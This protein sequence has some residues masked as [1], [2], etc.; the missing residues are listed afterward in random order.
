MKGEWIRKS[1]NSDL[2]VIFVHGFLS[3]GKD[4]WKNEE[5]NAYWPELLMN[6][7][8]LNSIGIY[9]YTYQTDFF[10]GS[11]NLGDVVDDLKE[12]LKLDHV[13]ESKNLVFVCHSMGGIVVRRY[14]VSRA[15]DL[16]EI[17]VGLYLVASPSLGSDYANWLGPIAQMMNHS[18]AD[19]LRFSQNNQWLNDL[20]KD[21]KNLIGSN[22]LT[23]YGKEIIED[24]FVILKK[25]VFLKQVV[26]P[27][28]GALYFPEPYKLPG[29]DHFSIAKPENKDSIQ[30]RL[31]LN[32]IALNVLQTSLPQQPEHKPVTPTE[33]PLANT[34][35]FTETST[36]LESWQIKL[37]TKLIEQLKKAELKQIVN[38]FIDALIVTNPSLKRDT[39]EIATYLVSGQSDRHLQ[40]A[41]YLTAVKSSPNPSQLTQSGTEQL[42]GYL[43]Q[44]LVRKNCESNDNGLT[45]IAVRNNETAKMIGASRTTYSYL[46]IYDENQREHKNGQ[47]DPFSQNIDYYFPETGELNE[48]SICNQ[49]AKDLLISLGHSSDRSNSKENPLESLIG[50]LS[51]YSDKPENAPIQALY[52]KNNANH[53]P[54][55]IRSVADQFRQRLDGLIWMYVYG[56]NKSEDWLHTSEA[57]LE[58]LMERYIW[59]KSELRSLQRSSPEEATMNSK[60]NLGNFGDHATVNIVTG[61]QTDAHVGHNTHQFTPQVS[62]Q[63]QRLLT[64][65]IQEA[66]KRDEINK[67]QF[68]EL[69]QAI[70]QIRTEIQKQ[71][72]PDSNVLSK[73]KIILEGFRTAEGIGTSVEKIITLL[74]KFI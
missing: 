7:S 60:F 47:K 30:H 28:T 40:I 49:I 67:A 56:E 25:M 12:R 52:L 6:E 36:Q 3:N 8:A 61:T 26:E 43:L 27:F 73:T 5:S 2:T 18:Q 64:E 54:L 37:R 24:K 11:Y 21:F 16:E 13:L 22:R 57:K 41:Q 35:S 4:C 31:L 50:I 74:A 69:S 62:D 10:S 48:A 51:A 17:T 19:V 45:K 29:S 46:P 20:N 34:V 38:V 33:K 14:L 32:F 15:Y 59:E 71:Q 68:A 42:F 53:N 55:H 58:G 63:L 72:N 65:V 39:E 66:D 70:N 1:S 44:T 23:I 9:I